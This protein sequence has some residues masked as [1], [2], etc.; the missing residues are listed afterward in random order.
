MPGFD[1][2]SVP[3][4]PPEA[5]FHLFR[6]LPVELQIKIWQEAAS[7]P[8][9]VLMRPDSA[10][11]RSA[12]KSTIPGRIPSL[13]HVNHQS[14][15]VCLPIYKNR[16]QIQGEND[17]WETYILADHDILSL[18]ELGMLDL[19]ANV[20]MHKLDDLSDSDDDARD[21]CFQAFRG[22]N[23]RPINMDAFRA[24]LTPTLKKYSQAALQP[25][26]ILGFRGDLGSIK[27]L[28]LHQS[29]AEELWPGISRDPD[30]LA[31]LSRA[32]PVTA[33]VNTEDDHCGHPAFAAQLA[34]AGVADL[35][36]RYRCRPVSCPRHPG[37]CDRKRPAIAL[38]R[39]PLSLPVWL[40][41]MTYNARAWYERAF[42]D[43]FGP[44][45]REHDLVMWCFC[46]PRWLAD[47]LPETATEDERAVEACAV[48][49]QLEERDI[50][51]QVAEVYHGHHPRDDECEW[52]G[53]D[54]G[55]DGDVLG[56]KDQASRP[57]KTPGCAL[58]D[59]TPYRS[60]HRTFRA[61]RHSC[62]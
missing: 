36:E 35:P 61:P 30:I 50:M 37:V 47:P 9:V 26:S 34:E 10:D 41:I 20:Q 4:H 18:D 6:R 31:N 1:N 27:W 22:P 28:M 11:T 51:F 43:S 23:D 62:S 15:H 55:E 2:Q 19:A 24:V 13:I 48:Y 44:P 59:G 53:S 7:V 54:E 17:L 21:R 25:P 38:A 14:R 56:T 49:A 16:L 29:R 42:D 12:D 57:P 8:R 60:L 39:S 58:C 32:F 3:S 45:D 52:L 46:Q 33:N 40:S 5:V